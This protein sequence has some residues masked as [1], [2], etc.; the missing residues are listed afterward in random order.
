MIV[1]ADIL[2]LTFYELPKGCGHPGRL[3]QNV[4]KG[5]PPPNPAALADL[6]G[7]LEGVGQ[8]I[9]RHAHPG[10]VD[11]EAANVLSIFCE[12]PCGIVSV[13]V[14]VGVVSVV[15]TEDR[16]SVTSVIRR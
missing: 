9:G 7:F 14:R 8:E 6:L 13:I 11:V 5:L 1:V 4:R 2:R 3:G 16:R 15:D 12:N 10:V